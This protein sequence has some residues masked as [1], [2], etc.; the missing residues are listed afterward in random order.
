LGVGVSEDGCAVLSHPSFRIIEKIL[1]ENRK[2]ETKIPDE[3]G[4][5][6]EGQTS[7]HVRWIPKSSQRRE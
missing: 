6:K 5:E 4:S 7:L 2:E 3:A 1:K